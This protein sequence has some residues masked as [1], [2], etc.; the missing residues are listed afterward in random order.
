MQ[1]NQVNY[2]KILSIIEETFLSTS[3]YWQCFS[4]IA[5][6][7]FSFIFYKI[8]RKF[9]LPK[10][11]IALRNNVELSRIILKYTLPLLYPLF[12]VILLSV[13]LSIYAQF[14]KEVILFSNTLKLMMLL[15]F[16]RFLRVSSG[17]IFIANAA[18]IFLMPALV[19]EVFGLLDSTIMYLD[20]YSLKLGNVRISIYLVIKTF[21]TLLIVFWFSNLISKKSKH[22]VESSKAMKSSTK[23]IISKF[24]DIVVYFIIAMILFKTIGVDM[25][26]F[27]VIGGAVGVGIGFGLQKIASNF[28][29]GI[30]LLL[31]KSVEIGDCVEIEGTNIFGNIRHFSG[32]Y[33]LIEC[34]DGREV[35]VPNEELIT[36]RVTNWTYSNNRARV[37]IDFGVAHGSDLKKV[38]D[39]AIAAA[40]EN[41]RCLT[42]PEVECFF[43][44]FGEFD[45]K[46]RLYFWISDINEGR[47][48]PK[49]EVIM[50]LC[51]GLKEGGIEIPLP[52]REVRIKSWGKNKSSDQLRCNWPPPN[53]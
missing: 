52:Q 10:V 24:I 32:R 26:T 36:N 25:T 16:L 30:I 13:G 21:I 15:L 12:S 6:F 27:A 46:V 3:F 22:Y 35:M 48:P 50:S 38:H 53:S 11:T 23:T 29:S 18:A 4:V 39:I 34:V 40:K 9:I 44:Q 37:Q 20:Q 49:S 14:F 28:I 1:S 51:Q 33:T 7:I 17:S 31:E 47:E 45:I 2:Y 42:Y 8:I 41:P 43:Y 5:C 19:L